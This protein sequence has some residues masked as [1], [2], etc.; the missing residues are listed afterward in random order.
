MTTT[1]ELFA[2]MVRAK[3]RQEDLQPQ[4]ERLQR[5]LQ[6]LLTNRQIVNGGD[7]ILIRTILNP[8]HAEQMVADAWPS[9][10]RDGGTKLEQMRLSMAATIAAMTAGEASPAPVIER[11]LAK[12]EDQ[13]LEL[14]SPKCDETND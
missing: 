7:G 4:V 13:F 1:R 10:K 6:A 12:Y 9:D 2:E 8:Q 3:H 14:L 11:L 5:H